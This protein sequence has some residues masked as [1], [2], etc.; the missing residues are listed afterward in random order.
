MAMTDEL[1]K[2]RQVEPDI[3]DR[4]SGR[5]QGGVTAG[6]G[7]R[8]RTGQEWYV[9]VPGTYDR[10]TADEDTVNEHLANRVYR[11]TR[12]IAPLT[13]VI[14][15]KR[16]AQP[17]PLQ[18]PL[19]RQQRTNRFA[20]AS[21]ILPNFST[22]L[23]Q[24]GKWSRRSASDFLVGMGVDA[25]LGINDMHGGN[26][27]I[28]ATPDG[29]RAARIDSGIQS[30]MSVK[31]WM[32]QDAH[33]AAARALKRPAKS[34]EQELENPAMLGFGLH[35]LNQ[36]RHANGDWKTFARRNAPQAPKEITEAFAGRMED[37]H[38]QLRQLVGRVGTHISRETLY[39]DPF[40][41]L[42][43]S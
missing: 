43:G 33:I 27:G 6:A 17:V 31:G 1:Y 35:R 40:R 2:A 8:D 26:V 15:L 34:V 38:N 21:K 18:T 14:D 20:I 23:E 30:A 5:G 7:F 19:G 9:K 36:V 22:L 10:A 37:R 16:L 29:H 11:A 3:L 28:V 13:H 24:G 4:P 39:R 12:N 41:D 42:W 32:P 25:G